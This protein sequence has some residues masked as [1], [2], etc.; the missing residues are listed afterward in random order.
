MPVLADYFIEQGAGHDR[1][2]TE[3]PR[4]PTL[5]TPPYDSNGAEREELTW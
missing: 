5:K 1:L 2:S 4:G 3:S